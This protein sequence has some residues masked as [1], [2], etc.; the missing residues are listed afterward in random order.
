MLELEFMRLALAV[1]AVVGVLA[2]ALADTVAH[3]AGASTATLDPLESLSS[4]D[5]HAGVDY[6]GVMRK[7]LDAL[8]EALG[9]T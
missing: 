2:P 7:N 8:R 9:C 6:F 1:G 3:E 5:E 4:A